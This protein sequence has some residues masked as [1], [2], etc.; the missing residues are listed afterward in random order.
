MVRPEWLNKLIVQY[1]AE[2][3]I[4]GIKHVLS[5]AFKE[6]AWIVGVVSVDIAWL[7]QTTT[8]IQ[9]SNCNL[10]HFVKIAVLNFR[11]ELHLECRQGQSKSREMNANFL[12]FKVL[13]F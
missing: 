3:F 12:L 13:F 8:A 10:R 1:L 6:H 11:G 7:G 4:P 2:T 9:N 5:S